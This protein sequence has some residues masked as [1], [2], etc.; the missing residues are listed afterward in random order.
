LGES[1]DTE[2]HKTHHNEE[3]DVVAAHSG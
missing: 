1:E 3:Y 2:Q